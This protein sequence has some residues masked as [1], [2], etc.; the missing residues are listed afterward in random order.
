MK[1][2]TVSSLPML[3]ENGRST[4]R[5]T[6]RRPGL[7]QMPVKTTAMCTLIKIKKKYIAQL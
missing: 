5:F 2:Q 4:F 7:K 3:L 6:T 1:N